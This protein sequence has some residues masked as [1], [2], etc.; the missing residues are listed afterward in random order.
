MPSYD[1]NCSTCKTTVERNVPIAEKDNQVC[2][3]CLEPLSQK[4]TARFLSVF[5][6]TAGGMR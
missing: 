2:N 3:V 5:A 1:Y 6:P 4:F